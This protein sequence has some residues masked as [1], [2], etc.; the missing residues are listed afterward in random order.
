MKLTD[1][2]AA[3]GAALSTGVFVWNAS[4]ARPK[5]KVRI[6]FAIDQ[7]KGKHEHGVGISIQNPSSHIAHI[8]NVSFFYPFQRPTFRNRLRY[9]IKY[10]RLRR[11]GWG[12]AALSLFKVKDGCPVSVEPSK[13]HW[14][15]VPDDVVQKI[16]SDAAK[17]CFAVV[18]QDA[19][20]RNK[21]SKPFKYDLP[22]RKRR[23]APKREG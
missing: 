16:L 14:I 13:N 21:Y 17:P 18:V 6:V 8:T 3:Y 15:F 2:L 1:L 9:F 7:I 19:L 12:S 5:I 4:R 10:R 22:R 23:L 20:W 11:V